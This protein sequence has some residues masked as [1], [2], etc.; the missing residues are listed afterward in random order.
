MGIPSW[1]HLPTW[2]LVS[3]NDKAIAPDEERFFAQRMG[4]T[5]VEI[6][7]SHV[8]MVS[9]PDEVA[10]LIEEAVESVSVGA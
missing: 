7:S 5:V 3:T 2:Y 10:G 4:A 9:H 8:A 6:A 1:K